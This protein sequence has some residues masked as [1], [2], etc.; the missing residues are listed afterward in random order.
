MEEEVALEVEKVM[1]CRCDDCKN[2][3]S[4][5]HT[6]VDWRLDDDDE[7]AV[8]LSVR[9]FYTETTHDKISSFLFYFTIGIIIKTL[10]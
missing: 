2:R 1:M 8:G 5:D 4:G 7:S 10:S 9:A 6:A 3:R